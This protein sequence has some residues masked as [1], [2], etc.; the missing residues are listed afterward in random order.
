MSDEMDARE[1]AMAA[2]RYFQDTK[3]VTKFFFETVS[4]NLDA[5]KWEVVCLVQ[6]LFEEEVQANCE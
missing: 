2:K 3:T 4:A 5:E 6:D 1:A